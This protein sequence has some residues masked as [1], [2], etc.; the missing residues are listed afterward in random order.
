MMVKP[1]LV[2]LKAVHPAWF[3]GKPPMKSS[4]QLSRQNEG[5]LPLA[6]SSRIRAACLNMLVCNST[7]VAGSSLVTCSGLCRFIRTV[8]AAERELLAGKIE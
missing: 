8:S 1:E 4:S 5:D 3:S 7:P 2:F 6:V